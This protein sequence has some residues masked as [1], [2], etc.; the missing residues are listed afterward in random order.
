MKAVAVSRFE[1]QE[2]AGF[3]DVRVRQ[4]RGVPVSQ[5]SG[6]DNCKVFSVLVR[7]FK[8]DKR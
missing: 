6:E 5:V 4:D 2:V 1:D 7:E 8:T 3:R